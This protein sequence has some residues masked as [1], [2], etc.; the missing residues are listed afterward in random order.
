MH[1][2]QDG[3]LTSRISNEA[4]IIF[5]ASR[6]PHPLTTRG[7]TAES[8]RQSAR[9]A[10]AVGVSLQTLY[11]VFYGRARKTARGMV[12]RALIDFRGWRSI[13]PRIGEKGRF[14]G[15]Y[16]VTRNDAHRLIEDA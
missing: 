12:P 2:R 6:P 4:V 1:V 16:A 3:Q 8:A 13:R 5:V 15:F 10:S 11:S 9:R 7:A 14:E